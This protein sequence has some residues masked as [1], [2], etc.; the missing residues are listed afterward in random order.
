LT[1]KLFIS[2]QYQF[3]RLTYYIFFA[4]RVRNY[5]VIRQTET[6]KWCAVSSI[7]AHSFLFERKCS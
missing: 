1:T 3:S 7:Q 2:V 6:I 5:F 4:I